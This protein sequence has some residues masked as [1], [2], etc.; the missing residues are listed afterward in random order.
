MRKTRRKNVKRS[1]ERITIFEK[2]KLRYHALNF[3]LGVQSTVMVLMGL[4]GELPRPDVIV[5]ADPM[6]EAQKSYENLEHIRPMIEKS[7]VP[8]E[9]VS[10]GNIREDGIKLHRIEMPFFI[11][12]T[13]YE[14]VEGKMELLIKDTTKAWKKEQKRKEQLQQDLFAKEQLSLEETIHHACTM[15]GQKVQAGEIKS[16]WM[17]MNTSQIGRQCTAKYKIRAVMDMLREKYGAS[18]KRPIGQWLGIT[19]DEFTRMKTSP[20]KSSILMY[21]LID[22]G[23]SRENCIEYCEDHNFPVPVKSACVSCPYHSNTLWN[24]LSDE[25]IE[26]S[27]DFEERN[28]QMIANDPKLKYL[29]YFSNGVRVHNSMQP[30][31]ERPFENKT[32][33]ET[34]HPCVSGCFL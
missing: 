30:I 17:D 28:I 22:L 8:F 21:P 1:N 24:T 20:V 18:P 4:N 11:N 33:E 9:I 23:M 6:W 26:E 12:S 32:A 15:F 27:A 31:D 25:Q 19:T 34:E 3:G 13:R 5:F 16:G 14:T 7:G 2:H 10:A 29:P